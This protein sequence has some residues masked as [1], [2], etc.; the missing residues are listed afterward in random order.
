MARR[1]LSVWFPR[2]AS[3][4]ALRRRPCEGAFALTLRSGTSDHLHCLTRTAEARGLRRGMSLADARAICPDLITRPTDLRSEAASLIALRRWMA[5]YAPWTAREGADGIVADITGVAH[6]FGGEAAMIADL[7]ARFDR[8]GIASQIG[9]AD[10]RGAAFALARHRGGIA[11]PG[12]TLAAIMALPTALLRIDHAASEG[13]RRLGL[14][15]IGDLIRLPR[16]PLA[17][18][19]GAGLLLRLDQAV[20]AQSEPVSPEADPPHYGVRLTLPEPI[21]STADVMAGLLRLL[22][23]LCVQLARQTA[24]ARRLRLEL[25]RV[26]GTSATVEIGLARP[27]RDAARMAAL[28]ARR[29]DAVDA[30]FGIECLRLT[31]PVVEPL[32]P[33]QT[34]TAAPSTGPQHDSD[35]LADLITRLGNRIGFENVQRS[36]PAESHVPERSFLI[37]AA[38]YAEPTEA[39]ANWSIAVPRPVTIFP[40]E[41]VLGEGSQP[42]DRFRWR[43]MEFTTARATGPERITSEWW[44]DDPAWRTGLRDYWR[45]ETHQGRRLWMFYTPQTPG[46]CVQ[47]EFA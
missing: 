33:T 21:G 38:A 19:F 45:V 46:W 41:P 43:R 37:V 3:D 1:I 7:C 39:P 29:I 8:A 31:A 9:L 28:F 17:R 6:L 42:P 40:A 25:R 20:G 36:L 44:F 10:T 18:R 2:L 34:T 11:A 15:Q 4:A 35:A 22:D 13:L 32:V 5:R 47:G 14:M 27:M 24:G 26:D 16:A 23:R 30:G 12:R